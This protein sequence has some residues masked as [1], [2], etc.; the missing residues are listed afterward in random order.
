MRMKATNVFFIHAKQFCIKVLKLVLVKQVEMHFL[1]QQSCK[2][3]HDDRG[4][5]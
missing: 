4:G 5:K 3:Q 2:I 1:I